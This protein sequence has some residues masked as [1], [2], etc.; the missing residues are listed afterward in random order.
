MNSNL[1]RREPR[2][3]L[4]I[5]ADLLQVAVDSEWTDERNEWTGDHAPCCPACETL[6]YERANRNYVGEPNKHAA[7]CPLD[8]LIEETRAY[9]RVENSLIAETERVDIP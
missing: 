3:H 5:V 1:M 7:T 6:M 8:A 2:S 4:Q 9:L